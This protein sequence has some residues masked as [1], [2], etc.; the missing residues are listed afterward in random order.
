V[1]VNRIGRWDGAQWSALNNGMDFE[2]DSLTVFDDGTGP[3]LYAGGGFHMAGGVPASGIA[4]W[5]CQPGP[6]PP[7]Q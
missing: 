2:V 3:G 5:R 7:A 4:A 1:V 6:L